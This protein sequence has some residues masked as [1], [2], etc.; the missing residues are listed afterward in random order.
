M[1]NV[2]SLGKCLKLLVAVSIL[3]NYNPLLPRIILINPRKIA[4]AAM[5]GLI[6]IGL[7]HDVEA[8]VSH[9]R[10][11]AHVRQLPEAKN[12]DGFA[13]VKITIKNNY[14]YL[15][16]FQPT[17]S[18]DAVLPDDCCLLSVDGQSVINRSWPEVKL[19]LAG[20]VDST[21]VLELVTANGEITKR[22][23]ARTLNYTQNDCK[24]TPLQ[25]AEKLKAIDLRTCAN[26]DSGEIGQNLDILARASCRQ[27]VERALIVPAIPD[28][29]N[30]VI[31]TALSAMIDL[32]EMG[33]LASADRYLKIILH[34]RAKKN[35]RTFDH[36]ALLLAVSNLNYSGRE[37]EALQLALM[38][39]DSQ[40]WH[41]ESPI[42]S[43]DTYYRVNFLRN[44]VQIKSAVKNS[45]VQAL[46]K[47][48]QIQYLSTPA[49]LTWL[50]NFFERSNQAAVAETIYSTQSACWLK[51]IEQSPALKLEDLQA[52]TEALYCRARLATITGN[53]KSAATFLES[54]L[55][56]LRART[57]EA[58]QK[59]LNNLP[60]YFPKP[61]EI[62][63]ALDRAQKRQLLTDV[64][65]LAVEKNARDIFATVNLFY[66]ALSTR[67]FEEAQ[68]ASGSLLQ[69][70]L[71]Q[72]QAVAANQGWRAYDQRHRQRARQNL[73]LINL[74]IA[75]KLADFGKFQ[76]SNK[77]IQAL[78]HSLRHKQS[79]LDSIKSQELFLNAELVFNQAQQ[80]KQKQVY[81]A[82][83]AEVPLL[84]RFPLRLLAMSY[85]YAGE[86]S[87]AKHFIDLALFQ[88]EGRGEKGGDRERHK[89]ASASNLP[90][91]DGETALLNLD[92]ACI[93]ASNQNYAK[94]QRYFEKG[95]KY[96]Q[97]INEEQVAA[98]V[99]LAY[100][101][102]RQN[103]VGEA[104]RVV[105]KLEA[106]VKSPPDFAVLRKAYLLLAEIYFE[107]HCWKQALD[108]ATRA[109][110]CKTLCSMEPY[111]IAGKSAE[112]LGDFATAAWNYFDAPD[113]CAERGLPQFSPSPSEFFREAAFSVKG[114]PISEKQPEL[115][116]TYLKAA[117]DYSADSYSALSLCERALSLMGEDDAARPSL[118]IR[119][120]KLKYTMD[121]STK[122]LQENILLSKLAAESASRKKFPDASKYWLTLACYEAQSGLVEAAMEHGRLA[123]SCF[124]KTDPAFLHLQQIIPPFGLTYLLK[125]H[126][127]GAQAEQLLQEAVERVSSIA[128]AG[129]L[130][131][132]AQMES[133]FEY[134]LQEKNFAKAD[135][136]L[137]RILSGNC[138]QQHLAE[139][140]TFEPDYTR[141]PKNYLPGNPILKSSKQVLGKIRN[142]ITESVRSTDCSFA[143]EALKQ[144]LHKQ[145]AEKPQGDQELVSTWVA[146]AR[147]YDR[148]E[149]TA[150]AYEAYQMVFSLYLKLYPEKRNSIFYPFEYLE[151]LTA[152]DKQ[153]ERDAIEQERDLGE[154]KFS[155]E[156]KIER[157]K[158]EVADK[159]KLEAK[160]KAI[161]W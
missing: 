77:V 30:L 101:F 156:G 76:L 12:V 28:D 149:D 134:Y 126:G 31:T 157:A 67:N 98:V 99:Q 123:I 146:I 37:L 142:A 18:Q 110:K 127:G 122:V 160:N 26:W 128:G 32:Q 50:G 44:V 117:E 56:L 130:E 48:I 140:N 85:H 34:D 139:S 52:A 150:S 120:C 92:A 116:A 136:I 68:R 137:R 82:K 33:E 7:Q 132:Q 17:F 47:Q 151:L 25:F 75:R 21:V 84:W 41:G 13:P 119:I 63:L 4:I 115:I 81:M 9:V 105:E 147:T 49:H 62:S 106:I 66:Q 70:Y 118:L 94:A 11:P 103:K 43:W 20:P 35:E 148:A 104:L 39:L 74:S 55:K 133:Q 51:K 88:A 1:N 3:N 161:K 65:T 125:K 59:R 58:Q 40:G 72:P 5:A 152:M 158:K 138:S 38:Y 89:D 79:E 54:A 29:S 109:T 83:S 22:S 159:A 15:L 46:A 100:I 144:I 27:A 24:I 95:M 23:L 143:Q 14:G 153:Q 71:A 124:D 111:Y 80:R 113:Y 16:D 90:G 6:S 19:L 42:D 60:L 121:N 2:L 73:Y 155:E 87:R 102:K 78:Q 131:A 61:R 69:R 112:K 135:E 45:K 86:Q 64:P 8:K 114:I 91:P 141:D 53:Y 108:A 129:S 36:D 57:S 107:K 10:P 154:A 145:E 96:R 97:A 93:Y